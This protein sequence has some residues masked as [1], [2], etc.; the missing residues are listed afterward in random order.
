MIAKWFRPADRIRAQFR[1]DYQFAMVVLFGVL[2]IVVVSGFVVYRYL[3]GF[4]FGGTVNLLIVIAMLLVLVYALRTG[5]TV[6]AGVL[7]TVVTVVACIAST[8]LFGRTGILWGY[9]VLWVTFLLTNRR[10][11]LL[12]NLVLMTVLIIETSL[13]QS[14]LEGVTYIVT[15]LMVTT[16]AWIF[17][18]RLDRYQQQLEQLAL[19][20]PL[21]YA[22]NRRM[23][24][25]DLNAAISSHRR[26]GRPYTL[27]LLD[28]DD[29]KRLN[30]EQGHDVGDQALAAFADLL[31]NQVRA[32]DGFYRFGGEEFVLLLPGHGDSTGLA[33]AESLHRRTSGQLQFGGHPIRFSGG[34]AVLGPEED[35]PSW[36]ARADRAMY[37]AKR[38]GRNR[39]VL[40]DR[41]IAAGDSG[42]IRDSGGFV[43]PLRSGNLG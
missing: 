39:I 8:A 2:A 33:T 36:M 25:R 37:R 40:A 23:M 4:V 18:G 16:F 32:E 14:V 20:D 15:A 28:L 26:D 7:F 19:Q 27:V 9:V 6:R 22:G 21:T 34:V 13:F 3:N 5:R 31:R 35:W 30:D 42:R 43:P 10:F 24:K 38:E 41:S 1:D 17:S 11:A 12:T 29:F